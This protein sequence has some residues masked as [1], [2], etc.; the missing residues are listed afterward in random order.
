MTD[1]AGSSGGLIAG[2]NVIAG[3][4]IDS[5]ADPPSNSSA[6]SFTVNPED[7][8]CAEIDISISGG[9]PPY[10]VSV[11]S[12]VNGRYGNATVQS[13]TGK[14]QNSVPSGQQYSMF[15]TD[16]NGTA[17]PVSKLLTSQLD[18]SICQAPSSPSHTKHLAAIIGGSVGGVVVLLGLLLAALQQAL[19]KVK[20]KT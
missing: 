8:A 11:L 9:V 15:V 19:F 18:S 16:A 2:Y 12:G 7:E 4:N 17:S 6:I 5:C 1:S 10:T 14:L 3:S 20:I 13:N